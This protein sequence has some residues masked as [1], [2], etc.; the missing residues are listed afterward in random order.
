[1]VGAAIDAFGASAP[2]AWHRF[3]RLALDGLRPG[4]ET[5]LPTAPLTR[6]QFISSIAH[7]G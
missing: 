2:G 7:P 4:A 1:M 6:E 3:T 5:G